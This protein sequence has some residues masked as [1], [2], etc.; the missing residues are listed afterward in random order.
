MH[1]FHGHGLTG[2]DPNIC[3]EYR[4]KARGYCGRAATDGLCTEHAEQR[5]GK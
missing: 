5:K 1:T 2:Y 4:G 3:H